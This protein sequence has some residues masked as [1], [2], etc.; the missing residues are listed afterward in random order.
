MFSFV[1]NN[2]SVLYAFHVSY[3]RTVTPKVSPAYTNTHA[4]KSTFISSNDKVARSRPP[5]PRTDHQNKIYH[6]KCSVLNC[7]LG[8][9]KIL[10]LP[11]RRS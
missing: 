7:Y 6:A 5:Y 8:S 4:K 11:N 2:S 9:K 1:I 3:E 10:P